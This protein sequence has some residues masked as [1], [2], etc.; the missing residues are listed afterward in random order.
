MTLSPCLDMFFALQ[1]LFEKDTPL[2]ALY[3]KRERPMPTDSPE[4][5]GS[6]AVSST[7]LKKSELRPSGV[8]TERGTFLDT[9][10]TMGTT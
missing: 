8:H 9:S 2:F 7:R 6:A 5:L 1:Y 3:P 10:Y 4:I